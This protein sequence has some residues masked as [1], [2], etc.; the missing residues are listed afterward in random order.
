[1]GKDPIQSEDLRVPTAAAGSTICPWI[2][3]IPKLIRVP[4]TLKGF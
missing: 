2:V 1:M 4:E 3:H